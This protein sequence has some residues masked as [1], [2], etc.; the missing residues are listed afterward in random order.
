MATI[1][2]KNI[3]KIYDGKHPAVKDI[4]LSIADGEFMTL[5]GPSGCGKTTFLRI[6]AGLEIPDK[7]E[8]I[9][10][11]IKSNDILPAKRDLAMVFQSYALYPHMTVY[12]NIAVGLRLRKTPRSE[13]DKR[14]KE[15]ASLLGLE[16]F[17]L[18]KPR[19]LSGGQRQRVALARAIVRKP[20]AFLLDEPLSNLDAT[21]REKTRSELKILFTNLKTTAIY[22]THDQ[23]EA[24]SLS[25]RIAVFNQGVLQQI[26]AP[27]EIYNKPANMFVAGFVGSPRMNFIKGQAE[28]NKLL[29]NSGTIGLPDKLIGKI[30][31][32]DLIIGIRPEDVKLY[33]AGSKEGLIPAEIVVREPQGAQISVML[34]LDNG[35]NI[36]SL[37]SIDAS[38][39]GKVGVEFNL[40]RLYLFDPESELLINS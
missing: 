12:E 24:M 2:L 4:S 33:P 19:A 36:K 6:I 27:E 31:I 3:T 28:G 8:I 14:V 16:T 34:K 37:I 22:V 39:S 20:Q 29:V 15:T 26:G 5:L 23:S 35:E 40:N 13:I 11:G 17:L 30:K 21:L 18:R 25:D 1:E 10:N 7:G 32:S 38:Y 9:I